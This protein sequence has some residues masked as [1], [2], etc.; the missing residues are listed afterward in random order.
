MDNFVN[1]IFS[2][3]ALAV[4]GA[5]VAAM[6]AGIGSAI[7]TGKT[8]EALDGVI[9]EDSTNY[10]SLLVMQLLPGT[11]GLYGFAIAMLIIGKLPLDL[12]SAQ[13]L[14]LLFAGFPVGIVGYFSAIA[15]SNAAT[16]GVGLIAKRASEAGKAITTAAIV[17][18]YALLGL[19]VSFLILNGVQ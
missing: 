7:G 16:A 1:I 3:K 14:M 15:Q 10:G 4:L 18:F 6:F 13:G 19:L 2:P 12:T 11:Q 5:V 9:S 17:E 8:G